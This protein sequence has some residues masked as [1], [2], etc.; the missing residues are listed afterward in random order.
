M[1]SHQDVLAYPG[2]HH[3]ILDEKYLA[4]GA[5][6]AGAVLTAGAEDG[7]LTEAGSG[8][9]PV[10][11]AHSG[12]FYDENGSGQDYEDGDV[13]RVVVDGAVKLE[14][15]GTVTRGEK[16]VA[17]SNGTVVSGATDGSLDPQNVVGVALEDGTD[18]D[19]IRVKL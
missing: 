2:D 5:V 18:G 13:L 15:N 19:L 16:L 7:E 8:D 11:V 3:T 9:I 14:A 10:A 6:G 1:V 17:G 4:D 12:N